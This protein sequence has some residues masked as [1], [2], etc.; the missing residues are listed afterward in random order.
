MKFLLALAH[1]LASTFLCLVCRWRAKPPSFPCLRDHLQRETPAPWPASKARQPSLPHTTMPAELSGFQRLP[2]CPKQKLTS[3]GAEGW[4]EALLAATGWGCFPWLQ[5]GLRWERGVCFLFI[6]F[7]FYLIE[8]TSLCVC[9]RETGRKGNV[10]MHLP[11]YGTPKGH[12][13]CSGWT[14]ENLRWGKQVSWMRTVPQHKHTY[15]HTH[16]PPYPHKHTYKDCKDFF[17]FFPFNYKSKCF[18]G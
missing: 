16:L 5:L 14:W 3:L 9:L 2:L 13:H 15:L 11:T 17:L 10:C 18:Q 1:G 7:A 6:L 12:T 4:K 8:V